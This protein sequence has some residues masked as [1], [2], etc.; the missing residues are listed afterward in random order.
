MFLPRPAILGHQQQ[1]FGQLLFNS[2]EKLIDK[3]R[4]DSRTASHQERDSVIGKFNLAI[5]ARLSTKNRTA[6]M[7]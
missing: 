2:V 3:I 1:H 7:L 5:I 6:R 4:L